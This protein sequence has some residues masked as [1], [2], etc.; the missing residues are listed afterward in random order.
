VTLL[1]LRDNGLPASVLELK[2]S[3]EMRPGTALSPAESRFSFCKEFLLRSRRGTK[4]MKVGMKGLEP[5]IHCVEPQI[6][7]WLLDAL[8]HLAAIEDDSW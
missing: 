7:R 3:C 4:K 1:T 2:Q 6:Q 5:E 8:T